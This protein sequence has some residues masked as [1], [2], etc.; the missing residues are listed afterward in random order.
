MGNKLVKHTK[1]K[2]TQ[3]NNSAKIINDTII[4]NFN[5]DIENT[6]YFINAM[7]DAFG[8]YSTI[9]WINKKRKTFTSNN[10]NNIVIKKNTNNYGPPKL[11]KKTKTNNNTNRVTYN[12]NAVVTSSTLSNEY[13][14]IDSLNT[15]GIREPPTLKCKEPSFRC[16]IFKNKKNN[17]YIVLLRYGRPIDFYD[18]DNNKK[19]NACCKFIKNNTINSDNILIFGWSQ[20][21]SMAQHIALKLNELKNLFIVSLCM[22]KILNDKDYHQFIEHYNGKYISLALGHTENEHNKLYID[23]YLNLLMYEGKYKTINT[24]ILVLNTFTD[25]DLYGKLINSILLTDEMIKN[26]KIDD[27]N[28][29][30]STS[31]NLHKDSFKLLYTL[32]TNN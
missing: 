9:D 2:N 4:K 22:G 20:G 15:C 19:I 10:K 27:I 18:S 23:E 16:T 25:K 29:Y 26:G 12:E 5:I 11:Y 31:S 8:L 7:Y 30:N 32:V 13:I 6:E 17:N 28:I 21:A 1:L 24:L 14:Y 3:K